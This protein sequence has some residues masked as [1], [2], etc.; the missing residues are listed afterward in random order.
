[1]TQYIGQTVL[2]YGF[3]AVF[4]NTPLNYKEKRINIWFIFLCDT[5]LLLQVFSLGVQVVEAPP[6]NVM[7]N[8]NQGAAQ[9][10][11]FLRK[12]YQYGFMF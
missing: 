10:H 1:M 6:F 2:K 7:N 11:F 4:H 5:W 8:A 9:L 12:K 3:V